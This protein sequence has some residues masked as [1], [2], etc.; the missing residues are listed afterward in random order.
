MHYD[1]FIKKLANTFDLYCLCYGLNIFFKNINYNNLQL[2]TEEEKKKIMF[3][4][5]KMTSFLRK[6]YAN[7]DK[8]ESNLNLPRDIYVE[9]L[10]QN[11]MLSNNIY[12]P[13]NEVLSLVKKNSAEKYIIREKS[14]CPENKIR[15]PVTGRCVIKKVKKSKSAKMRD[16]CPENKVRN[17]VTG[18]C[19]TQK[20]KI[21]KSAKMREPCPENKVRNP[22]TG[23]CVT[24]KKKYRN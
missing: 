20:I 8:R 15:N 14:S 1:I 23:R 5:N 24:Q 4:V 19:V 6:F 22:K 13:S 3:I 10:R 21:S 2:C 18:R 9:L 16:P 17:P 11:D 7:I 12:K